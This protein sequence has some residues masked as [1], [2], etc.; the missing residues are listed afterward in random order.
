MIKMYT[1]KHKHRYYQNPERNEMKTKAPKEIVHERKG[2]DFFFTD[3]NTFP[4]LSILSEMLAGY[5][6]NI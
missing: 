2:P 6:A 4:G 3:T 5:E 1:E